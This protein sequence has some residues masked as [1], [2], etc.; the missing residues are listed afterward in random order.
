MFHGTRRRALAR[1]LA[2]VWMAAVLPTGCGKGIDA[3]QVVGTWTFYRE[4]SGEEV[5]KYGD[6]QLPAGAELTM[7]LS[8]TET[9]HAD[10]SYRFE[11]TID[12][13]IEKAGRE[14]EMRFRTV[15]EGRWTL[16]DDVLVQTNTASDVKPGNDLTAKIM[17]QDDSLRQDMV[18]QQGETAKARILSIDES[19]MILEDEEHGMRLELFRG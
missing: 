19:K 18:S 17:A 3:Q 12:M 10:A 14:T 13:R 9:F 7:K 15:E 2:I 6:A 8:G 1:L 4:L 5:A 11:T 16:E